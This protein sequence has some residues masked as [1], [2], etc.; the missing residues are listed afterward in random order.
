MTIA[1]WPETIE[2][3]AEMVTAA[4]GCGIAIRPDHA[5]EEEVERLFAHE[6]P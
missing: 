6:I 5:V 2:E 1:G 3:T 4:A